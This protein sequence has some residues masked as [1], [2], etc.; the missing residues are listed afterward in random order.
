MFPCTNRE[1]RFPEQEPSHQTNG[2][3]TQRH[4]PDPA[5][6]TD[7][8]SATSG[9][10][11]RVGQAQAGRAVNVHRNN[12]VSSDIKSLLLLLLLAQRK[13]RSK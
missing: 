7:R 9:A 4:I 6:P 11:H 13:R 5:E 10:L 3:F 12:S 8:A 1:G 2:D